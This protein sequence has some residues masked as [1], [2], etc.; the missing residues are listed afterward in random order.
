[1]TTRTPFD[2]VEGRVAGQYYRDS[3]LTPFVVPFARRV[4]RRFVFQDNARVHRAHI[5]NA[6][7]QQHNIYRMPWPA[8]SPDISLIEH[9]CGMIGRR[10][11]QRQRPRTTLAELSQALQ[12]EWD[13]FPQ[14]AIGRIIHNMLRQLNECLTN[15]G[16]I[17]H[18][19]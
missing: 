7:L 4:G 19:W 16:G 11:R 18:Y 3:I 5:A 14:T 12:E 10:V 13:R 15:C 9:V 1:M 2:I 17:T 8:M 6:H